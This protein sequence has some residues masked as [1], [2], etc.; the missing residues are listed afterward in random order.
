MGRNSKQLKL[1]AIALGG[2]LATALAATPAK[3]GFFDFLFGGPDKGPN[4]SVSSYANPSVSPG[5]SVGS[6][7]RS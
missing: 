2:V 1:Q 7:G 3:A 6:V 5:R 4:P